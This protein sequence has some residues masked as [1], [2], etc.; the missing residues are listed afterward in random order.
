[1]QIANDKNRDKCDG[2]QAFTSQAIVP[3]ALT[4]AFLHCSFDWYVKML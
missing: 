2:S 1:M 3:Y 4:M